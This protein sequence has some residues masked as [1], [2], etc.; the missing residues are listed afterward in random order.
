MYR[1]VAMTSSCSLVLAWVRVQ[2][3]IYRVDRT[4]TIVMERTKKGLKKRTGEFT[5]K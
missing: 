2:A 5:N 3:Y 1:L 4:L